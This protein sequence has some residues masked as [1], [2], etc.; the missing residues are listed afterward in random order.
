M[1]NRSQNHYAYNASKAAA[2]HLTKML[3]SEIVNQGVRV[4]INAIAPGVFP[5]EMTAKVESDDKQK[6]ELDQS[7]FEHLPSRRSGSDRDMA[8]AILFAVTNQYL[9]G[10]NIAVDGGFLLNTGT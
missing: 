10:Q 4:R 9:N 1:T 3:S 5:S 2:I 6:N 7:K 8:Q